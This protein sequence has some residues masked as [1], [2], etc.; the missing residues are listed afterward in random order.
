[1]I[2][3]VIETNMGS[4]S[5]LI[6]LDC[7]ISGFSCEIKGADAISLNDEI[8]EDSIISSSKLY[9]DHAEHYLGRLAVRRKIFSD[10][11]LKLALS[12]I[13][14]RVPVDGQLSQHIDL[15]FNDKKTPFDMELPSQAFNLS[16][17]I[18]TDL[19][20]SDIFDR[21][22]KFFVF[23]QDYKKS[24]RYAY[25]LPRMGMAG[26][27]VELKKIREGGRTDF[28]M[29]GSNDY[30]NLSTHPSVINSAIEA[31]KKYGVGATGTAPT[32]GTTDLH[33]ELSAE[34]ARLYG[35]E[36]CLIFASGYNTNIGVIS[37][38]ARE[39]DLLIA[40]M[41]SHASIQDGMNMSRATTRFFKHNNIQHLEKILSEQRS[42]HGGC[43]ILTEGIFSMDGT[44]GNL[45]GISVLAKKYNARIFVD[46]GHCLGVL[47]KN[48][49]GTSEDTNTTNEIDLIMGLYSKALGTMGGFIVGD[50][51]IIS[52]L[53]A[54]ARS[55]MFATAFPPA[56]AAATL[57]SLRILQEQSELRSVLKN[58]IQHFVKSINRNGT[59]VDPE[60]RTPIIPLVIG[61]EN[62]M[63]KIF[64]SLLADGVFALPVMYP[65]VA[66]NK[67]R[68]RFSITTGHSIS[69][70]DYA[71]FA[72]EKAVDKAGLSLT[73]ISRKSKDTKSSAA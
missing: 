46:Q 41:L 30:L 51:E 67:C 34:T 48:G 50:K 63:G 40:D 8:S 19:T 37:G 69:D 12:T 15:D 60:H 25:F 26:P 21:A 13:D 23:Y 28:L 32:S 24:D 47:G 35:K 22:R 61:D 53:R 64:A 57:A 55:Y 11:C 52:W 43:L 18:N 72:I 49:L 73:E 39:Q 38:L 4:N 36:D 58:N 71:I 5:N 27:R 45:K 44:I 68:F 29:F 14:T 59:V 66:K 62:K 56:V 54:Y 1:M 42:R 2:S 7:S 33:E 3:L 17:F 31:I 6:V 65:V 20:N 16:S 70:I 10:G 9:I